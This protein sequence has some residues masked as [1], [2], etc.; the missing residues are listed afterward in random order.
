MMLALIPSMTSRDVCCCLLAPSTWVAPSSAG[1]GAASSSS[2]PFASS[3]TGGVSSI[4]RELPGGFFADV[5]YAG[6]RGIHLER[7]DTQVN[8]IPDSFIAEAAAQAAMGNTPDIAKPAAAYPFNQPLPGN[9]L[10]GKLLQGQLDRPFP[11]Y[12]NLRYNGFA[13]CDSYYHSLQATVTKR[14]PGGGTLLAAYTNAKLISNTDTLTDWLEGGTSGGSGPI[15][16]WNNLKGEKSLSAQDV[17]QRLVISYVLDLP[18]GK[19]KKYFNGVSGVGSKVVSGWGVDGVTTFQRGFP[20]KIQYGQGN[21]LTSLGLTNGNLRPDVVSGCDK[22]VSGSPVSKLSGWFNTSCF[23]PPPDWGFGD[24]SR[25]DATLRQQGINNFDFAVFKKTNLTETMNIEFRTEFF[26]IFNHPQ[27][28]PPNGT[29]SSP[30]FGVVT[31]TI[32]NP[33]L[34]QFALRFAF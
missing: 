26:N 11:Q 22:N 31:N 20:V 10:P 24:E 21:S 12:G 19:G 8:Q 23:V 13:C 28:G 33:R 4:Q 7:F 32:N 16:D 9:L 30:N 15:Q 18:F 1:I 14:F 5:A 34:I 3:V 29:L 2:A 6:S 17:S 27:F 25:V